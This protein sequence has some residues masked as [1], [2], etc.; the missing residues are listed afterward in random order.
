MAQFR[1]LNGNQGIYGYM[2][3]LNYDRI[4][5]SETRIVLRYNGRSGPYD[6]A[7][8]PWRIDILYSGRTYFVPEDGPMAGQQVINGGTIHTLRFYNQSGALLLEGTQLGR[9]LALLE[10][11]LAEDP[12]KLWEFFW[13]GNNLYT[14]SADAS[15][16][17]NGWTGDDIHSG[18]GNDTV[19]GNAGD[20]FISDHGGR[21]DYRGGAGNDTVNYDS[22]FWNPQFIYRGLHADLVAGRIVGSDGRVDLINSIEG[23]RGT[24]MADVFIGNA[25]NNEFMGLRGADTIDGGAGLDIVSYLGDARQA[26]F[27]G[28]RINLA[29]GTGRDGYGHVDRLTRIEGAEGTNLRDIF[30]DNAGA[31]FF[32]GQAG[33][34]EFRVSGGPDTLRGEAGA[35]RFVFVGAAFGADVI[36]DFTPAA[37]DRIEVVQADAFTDFTIQQDGT[38]ALVRFG[39]SQIRL[40]GWDADALQAGHFIF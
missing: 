22:V 35:D 13:A 11:Y 30:I 10:I 7:A 28:A 38:S 12:F 32:R 17:Q 2:D 23:V 29:A 33:N 36:E 4:S 21:D 16:P 27:G 5:T 18:T 25:K 14:G 15:G 39:G 19:I 26:G 8:H 24:Y 3:F 40:L 37:G 6:P 34:D 31:N 9:D 20:D 1:W